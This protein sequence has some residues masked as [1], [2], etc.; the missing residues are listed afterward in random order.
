MALR[1]GFDINVPESLQKMLDLE[2]RINDI[3]HQP[4]IEQIERAIEFESP[5]AR[6]QET[7]QGEAL[8][9]LEA[10]NTA[11]NERALS[12]TLREVQDLREQ[13][14]SALEQALAY[15][16]AVFMAKIPEDVLAINAELSDMGYFL[17]TAESLDKIV[18]TREY[19]LN[20]QLASWLEA[21]DFSYIPSV[22]QEVQ[23][24]QAFQL[25]LDRYRRFFAQEMYDA[26]WFPFI[27]WTAP[28]KLTSRL[29]KILLH[30]RKSKNRIKQIDKAVFDY[31]TPSRIKDIKRS[32]RNSDFSE[33]VK[34]I[35]LQ[36]LKAY[37]N[38]EYACV[39]ITLSSLWQ[40]MI[41]EKASN[42]EW[43]SDGETV[44]KFSALVERNRFGKLF[45]SFFKE[46]IMM[47]CHGPQEAP[48]DIPTRNGNQHG[49]H[50]AMPTWKAALNAII[51]TDFLVY[52]IPLEKES[53][54]T[55]QNAG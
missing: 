9:A 2:K 4:Y 55:V 41:Y 31:F 11:Y 54:M 26:R 27:G 25:D 20:D 38:K 40:T 1:D 32:W 52:L 19:E 35:M 53:V 13:E 49:L 15:E 18:S 43:R 45:D 8:R 16:P 12:E 22:L 33:P 14:L 36:A 3:F 44:S 50:S 47:K 37:L 48:K 42:R 5:L 7:Y 29:N 10:A 34:G 28:I 23:I 17:Q 6:L 30:T 21:I 39:S 46:F 24:A 51:L